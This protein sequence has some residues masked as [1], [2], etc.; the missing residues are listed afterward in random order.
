MPS[1]TTPYPSAPETDIEVEE[2]ESALQNKRRKMH[3]PPSE[4]ARIR[5]TSQTGVVSGDDSRLLKW[6]RQPH[7]VDGNGI[8][9]LTERQQDLLEILDDL[10][11]IRQ[12][13]LRRNGPHTADSIMS[14]VKKALNAEAILVHVL[15]EQANGF[16]RDRWRRRRPGCAEHDSRNEKGDGTRIRNVRDYMVDERFNN[17]MKSAL[18]MDE[19]DFGRARQ[20][21]ESEFE[22][23]AAERSQKLGG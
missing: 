13:H 11:P 17:E 16:R 4:P 2:E 7:R 8:K 20:L 23:E 18:I 3:N 5:K 14:R 10:G 22:H 19:N 12:I 15:G 21:Q 9:K 1:G 6:A